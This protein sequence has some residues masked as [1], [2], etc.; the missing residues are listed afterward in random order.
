VWSLVVVVVQPGIQI[1]LQRLDAVKQLLV[2][3]WPEELLSTVPLKRSTN[4]SGRA[5]SPGGMSAQ[6]TGVRGVRTLVFRCS[7]SFSAR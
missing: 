4:P 1:G 3:D 2:H 6:L 7:L 5:R